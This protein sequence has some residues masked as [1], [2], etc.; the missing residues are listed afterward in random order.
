VAS[1]DSYMKNSH[2]VMNP[3]R[4]RDFYYCDYTFKDQWDITRNFKISFPRAY[5]NQKIQKFGIPESLVEPF[6]PT[7]SAINERRKIAWEGL[8]FINGNTIEIDKSAVVSYY[9]KDFCRPISNF[10]KESL[11]ERGADNRTERIQM[12][13]K[14]VQDIPYGIPNWEKNG[15]YYGGI[16]TP[17]EILIYGYGDCDSKAFLF[18]CILSSLIDPDDVVFVQHD[19][20]LMTAIRTE[21]IT[22]LSYISLSGNYYAL[23]ETSGP[24][25]YNLG[26]IEK[27][28]TKNILAE[29]L[30]F[31]KDIDRSSSNPG[32]KIKKRLSSRI[33]IQEKESF[34]ILFKNE[35]KEDI[36]LLVH[37]FDLQKEWK[38]DGWYI[39]KPGDTMHIANSRDK[40][41]YYYAKCKNGE[42]SGNSQF[43][44]KGE[45]YKFNRI[46]NPQEGFEDLMYVLSGE[47]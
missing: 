31:Q 43:E 1:Q 26:E 38:T 3:S 40:T 33:I 47:E 13:M 37:Y 46:Y 21:S 22:G 30:E 24:A 45:T 36:K 28:V 16:S 2:V 6:A 9:E 10:I 27:G 35:Y 15:N 8:F 4:D 32:K 39:V 42:W 19:Q 18:A 34:R 14:F 25:R 20:H 44:F 11:K 41:F 5:T 12:A 29:K 23:A 7:E 17:P